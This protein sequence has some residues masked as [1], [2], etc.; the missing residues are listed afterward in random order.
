L[1]QKMIVIAGTLYAGEIKK[2]IY[3]VMN[4][5]P[6]PQDVL[7]I[8][9]SANIGPDGDPALFL[10]ARVSSKTTL[11]CTPGRRLLG[12][13]EHGWG[14][15]ASSTSKAAAAPASAM[16]PASAGRSLRAAG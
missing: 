11:A 8:H 1:A 13:D 3:T 5:L 14:R 15:R 4:W 2:S 6:P 16:A 9:C 12:D 10:G 7:P